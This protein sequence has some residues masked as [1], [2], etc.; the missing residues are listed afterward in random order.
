MEMGMGLLKARDALL[1]FAFAWALAGCGGGTEASGEQS[2]QS[3][4]ID[5][6][7]F[8][9]GRAPRPPKPPKP[10]GGRDAPVSITLQSDAGDFVGA[11][12]TWSYTKTNALISVT[13]TNGTV[14]VGINGNA[15]WSG[16]FQLPGAPAQLVRTQVDGV[17]RYPIAGAGNGSLNWSG[18]GRGCNTLVGSFSVS[19]VAYDRG[20]LRAFDLTFEQ[21]CEGAAPA[22][23]GQ[24]HWNS[25]DATQP[26]GPVSPPPAGL[27]SPPAHTIPATG[28]S[29]YLQSEPGDYVGAGE[30]HL[31][32]QA[33]AVLSMS[34][35]G[36]HVTFSVRG[37]Q[38]W[39][40][41]FA[42]MSSAP[43]LAKG[44]YGNL[45][46][47]PFNN[48]VT[49]G[50]DWS[51]N[52]RGCNT[53]TGWFVV[54]DV[55]YVN[56]VLASIKL[57]FEQHCEGVAPALHGQITWTASDST[58]A[59][60]PAN[61]P[62]GLWAPPANVIPATG[63]S[64]YLQSDAGDYVGAGQTY[65]YTQANA[66]IQIS[67]TPNQVTFQVNGDKRWSGDFAA[68]STLPQLQQG[69]YG[70]L[71]RF[72]FH[73]PMAGGLNWSGDGRGCN[74]LTGWFVVDDVSYVNGVLASI[75]LRFEQHCEGLTPALH[76]QI[77]W[78]ATDNT[79]LPGPATPPA[80]LWQPDAAALPA[81]GNYVYLQ[82]QQGDYVVGANSYLYTSG[83]TAGSTSN[84]F[85]VNVNT[86]GDWWSGNFKGMSSLPLLQPGYYGGL[87]RYPFNN[88]MSGG[89]DWS[90]NGRGCN[91]ETGWFVVDS[92]SYLNGSLKSI[93]LR[94]EQSCEGWMPPLH[95][96]IHWSAP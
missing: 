57:R 55:S 47:Y 20:T 29:I 12:R 71:Q 65:L 46:R 4:S 49:G 27:W 19:N 56:G 84:L 35:S 63:R 31:F 94:F 88:P 28:R 23:R 10:P 92:V 1:A 79:P 34:A 36:A 85:N 66:A 3:A 81:S 45:Q 50:M 60:G 30:T 42:A 68:M 89:L 67:G 48:P 61:P 90:G 6:P 73:N 59:P 17:G 76:G 16:D 18:D 25:A 37:N 22:L 44:Y 43:Q 38:W 13:Y 87:Q 69:Y 77:T 8:A 86:N 62:P 11:G 52:G 33:D 91:Q 54:D 78:T 72:P 40:G 80:G 15:W 2:P 58:A 51:G 26:P 96:A 5:G 9:D 39:A 21:H 32:T 93:D 74:T 24:I 7:V 83:F 64:I 53:L 41:N 70:N 14:H 95:G 75:K 82:G